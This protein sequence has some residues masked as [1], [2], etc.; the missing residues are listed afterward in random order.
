MLGNVFYNDTGLT[1]KVNSFPEIRTVIKRIMEP[2][3]DVE[4][5]FENYY[6]RLAYFLDCLKNRSYPFE[7]NVAKLD[8][9][10][11]VLAPQNIGQFSN[12]LEEILIRKK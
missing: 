2:N 12:C 5:H 4:H 9:K 10:E 11:R 8:T 6:A 7:F 3:F 1:F